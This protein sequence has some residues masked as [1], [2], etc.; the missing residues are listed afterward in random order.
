MKFEEM[1]KEQAAKLLEEQAE[2]G[3]TLGGFLK[4]F[5]AEADPHFKDG[6][7]KYAASMIAASHNIGRVMVAAEQDDETREDFMS[8][9]RKLSQKINASAKPNKKTTP[10]EEKE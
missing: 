4:R 2:E 9:L 6:M 7:E 5:L 3:D 1:T 8:R 10:D